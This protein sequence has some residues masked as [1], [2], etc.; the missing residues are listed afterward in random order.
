MPLSRGLAFVVA[1][2]LIAFGTA[3][4]LGQDATAKLADVKAD[5]Q[6]QAAAQTDVAADKQQKAALTAGMEAEKKAYHEVYDP[7]NADYQSY[8]PEGYPRE[9]IAACGAK[10]AQL[11]SVY[12]GYEAKY[13]VYSD[14]WDAQNAAQRAAQG[15]LDAAKARIKAQMDVLSKLFPDCPTGTSDL[16]LQAAYNCMSVA[17]DGAK[18]RTD[19]VDASGKMV[20]NDYNPNVKAL[21]GRYQA[22]EVKLNAVNAKLADLYDQPSSSERNMAITN[23]KTNRSAVQAQMNALQSQA[24]STKP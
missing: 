7:L 1:A 16:Q 18:H 12:A 13:K 24:L 21:H 2:A 19:A 5:L 23:L 20:W 3:P 4:C 15:R 17:W 6:N 8:C 9:R 22:L 10:Y 11:H 14:A